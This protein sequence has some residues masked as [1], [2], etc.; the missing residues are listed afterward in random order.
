MRDLIRSPL[1]F[2]RLMTEDEWQNL[3]VRAEQ[4]ELRRKIRRR[5]KQLAAPVE[6]TSRRRL[7]VKTLSQAADS[8][9]VF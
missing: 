9:G 1:Q 4:R 7:K 6:S 2:V 8:S 3:V 5:K